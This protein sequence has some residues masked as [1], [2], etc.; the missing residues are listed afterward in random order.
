MFVLQHKTCS[1]EKRG[2]KM[3]SCP[4]DPYNIFLDLEVLIKAADLQDSLE[5]WLTK[6]WEK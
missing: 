5:D 1:A 2:M 4:T 3:A 6:Q